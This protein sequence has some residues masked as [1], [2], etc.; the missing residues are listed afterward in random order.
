MSRLEDIRLNELTLLLFLH[1]S[2]RRNSVSTTI[3]DNTVHY[4]FCSISSEYNCPQLLFHRGRKILQGSTF[5]VLTHL[6]IQ[7]LAL[8][9]E[10]CSSL[11]PFP[12]ANNHSNSTLSLF[13]HSSQ[14]HNCLD[15]WRWE[16]NLKHPTSIYN[17]IH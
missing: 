8:S 2:H 7:L 16:I 1:S 4:S 11:G 14:A 15:S 12:T 3:S 13:T 9:R 6:V 5:K 10:W 17:C